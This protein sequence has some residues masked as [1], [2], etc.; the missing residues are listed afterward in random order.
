[1]AGRLVLAEGL[2][3]DAVPIVPDS[4]P[5]KASAARAIVKPR[6]FSLSDRN[7]ACVYVSLFRSTSP[8]VSRDCGQLDP[9]IGMGPERPTIIRAT[10]RTN[11]TVWPSAP[12]HSNGCA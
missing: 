3:A 11:G 10:T 6:N 4:L 5:G 2:S 7:F 1:M 12:W 8:D 9:V